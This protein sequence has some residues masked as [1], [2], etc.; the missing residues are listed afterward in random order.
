MTPEKFTSL[1][2]EKLP[3]GLRAVLLYGSA[4]AGDFQGKKSDYNLLIVME[5]LGLRELRELAALCPPWLKAGNPAP[6][7][8]TEERLR[9]STDTFPLEL[10]DIQQNHRVLHGENPLLDLV[11]RPEHL[12]LQLEREARS[13]LIQIREAFLLTAGKTDAVRQLILESVSTFLVL[14]RGTLRFLGQRPPERK[15][16]VP[17]MLAPYLPIDHELFCL[18]EEIRL[19]QRTSFPP[20]PIDALF[21]RYL[22]AVEQFVDGLDSLFQQT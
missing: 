19:G 9:R 6:L 2:T 3:E 17:G 12:R 14:M 4:A 15:V 16:E 10:L 21:E 20:E 13:R 7:L 18:L 8:F 11:I 5:S 22:K 1:L